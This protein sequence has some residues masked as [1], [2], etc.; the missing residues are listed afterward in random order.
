MLFLT[1]LIEKARIGI[2]VVIKHS[3]PNNNQK[4]IIGNMMSEADVESSLNIWG[5]RA[6][7]ALGAAGAIYGFGTE[8]THSLLEGIRAGLGFAVIGVIL[9]GLVWLVIT[10]IHMALRTAME[11]DNPLMQGIM[12]IFGFITLCGVID[13]AFLG[14]TFM[15]RPLIELLFT[16]DISNS[17]WGCED[18]IT[19][20]EG[21]YCADDN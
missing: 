15:L 5:K 6:A 4:G 21:S 19:V 2:T 11:Y 14:G 13:I 17:F 10:M 18:Y 7:G 20:E 9:A 1:L 8:I 3:R 12:F 16:G